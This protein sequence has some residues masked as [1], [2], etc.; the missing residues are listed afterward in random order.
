[1]RNQKTI[2]PWI[3]CATASRPLPRKAHKAF[4]PPVDQHAPVIQTPH[5]HPNISSSHSRFIGFF[6]DYVR[7]RSVRRPV[8]VRVHVPS[9]HVLVINPGASLKCEKSYPFQVR[10]TLSVLGG[11]W[12]VQEYSWNM[13]C[14]PYNAHPCGCAPCA[15][16]TRRGSPSTNSHPSISAISACT[17]LTD[18]PDCRC[19]ACAKRPATL[20]LR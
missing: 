18:A 5:P 14:S 20:R 8:A 4:T 13:G 9:I 10:W 17:P 15:A 7:A 3:D 6:F 19:S 12:S 16:H 1:M 11:G 2:A